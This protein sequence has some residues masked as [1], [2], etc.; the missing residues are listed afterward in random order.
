MRS[1]KCNKTSSHSD[2]VVDYNSL[3]EV[4]VE[5]FLRKE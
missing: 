2:A 1:L 4:E 5:S 3:T